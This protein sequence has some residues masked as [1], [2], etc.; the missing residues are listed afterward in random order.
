MNWVTRVFAAF[1][2]S[3]S[4]ASAAF[5]QS[6][7]LRDA[8]GEWIGGEERVL[9]ARLLPALAPFGF[10]IDKVEAFFARHSW[11]GRDRAHRVE[12]VRDVASGRW[13]ANP[14]GGTMP[15]GDSLFV[16]WK[17]TYRVLQI[18]GPP[19]TRTAFSPLSERTIG[20]R[21]ADINADL[22]VLQALVQSLRTPNPHID[23]PLRGFAV[24]THLMVSLNGI[25]FTMAKNEVATGANT[26][27]FGLPDLVVYAPR[28]RRGNETALQY[29][30]ALRDGVPDPPYRLIGWA[31]AQTQRDV[32]RRPSLGCVPSKHWF[33]HEAGFHLANGGFQPTPPTTVERIR[34]SNR[35][36]VMGDSRIATNAGI[37]PARP[38]WHP[39]IW[40]LHMWTDPRPGCGFASCPPLIRITSPVAVLGLPTPRSTFFVSQTFE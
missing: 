12:S 15:R 13:H 27:R 28:N 25:G 11:P 30:I 36:V 37:S 21:Q 6:P 2:I 5:A 3:I 32:T 1:L 7:Q 10:R 20:C 4:F 34:G 35:V 26:V 18:G 16:Q 40:D 19:E 29:R 33:I 39:R 31:Y 14:V 17:M 9:K 22:A 24:P 23:L 38:V 8:T